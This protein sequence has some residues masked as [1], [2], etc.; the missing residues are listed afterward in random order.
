MT[1]AAVAGLSG[2]SDVVAR[3]QSNATQ[4]A[5]AT[6]EFRALQNGTPLFDL[7]PQE[8]RLRVDNV[9]LDLV[10]LDLVGAGSSNSV[11]PPPFATNGASR[12]GRDL[13]FVLD[14]ESYQ[15]GGES[16]VQEVVGAALA[17]LT[18]FDR[19]G[20]VSLHPSGV[21]LALTTSQASRQAALRQI[22]GRAV[23][24]EPGTNLSCRTRRLIPVIT[25][26]FQGVDTEVNTTIVLFS[27]AL[28]APPASNVVTPGV[29]RACQLN[30]EDFD[31][32]RTASAR[33]PAQ[34]YAIHLADSAA[35]VDLRNGAGLERLAG[36]AGGQFLR[37][38]GDPA[39]PMRRIVDDAGGFY[40]ATVIIDAGSRSAKRAV[41]LR[42]L[43]NGA[44]TR[45]K[46]E[47]ASPVIESKTVSTRDMIRT[48][49]E[50]RALQ[51]RAAAFSSRD[52]PTTAKVVV[53]LE[54]VEAGVTLRSAMAGLF[55]AKGK[56]IA[57]WE[58]E[59]TELAGQPVMAGLAAASGEYR[60]RVTAV[61]SKGRSGAVDQDVTVGLSPAGSMTMSGII[62]GVQGTGPFFPRLQITAADIVAHVYFEA[63]GAA[64]CAG[65]SATIEIAPAVKA[66]AIVTATAGASPIEK[67]DGCILFG[68]FPVAALPP[69]DY[70]FR[71]R[72]L[73][74][75]TVI[76]ERLRT[77]RKTANR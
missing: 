33:S 2:A 54:P 6:I 20:L 11:L 47:L 52:T 31:E 23:T 9:D 57:Q 38:S 61:D 55:D 13:L 19:A 7:R 34:F 27:A 66:P 16:R 43:R 50:F 64:S 39:P 59:S 44:T 1:A 21:S 3:G 74:G 40:V 69:G 26:L 60:L 71:V 75:E 53:L 8:I 37:V 10:S 15:P 28:A 30:A 72:L 73:R 65:L 46:R 62:L 22:R 63:Y 36:E 42:V 12:R 68:E 25:S 70:A 18:T 77:L 14:E 48:P 67:S 41:D 5:L 51:L 29:D 4:T 58:G 56:L 49:S 76:S 32:F 45:Y 17:Q 24:T 35:T